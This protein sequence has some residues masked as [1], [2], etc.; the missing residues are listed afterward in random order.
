MKATTDIAAVRREK[1]RLWSG[2]ESARMLAADRAY[3]IVAEGDSWFDYK[4]GLD[5][6][7]FLAGV[8]G[9]AIARVVDGGD[10]LENMAYG[11]ALTRGLRRSRRQQITDTIAKVRRYQ[12]RIVLLSAG[13]N[14][15]S[16]SKVDRNLDNL[17]NHKESRPTEALRADYLRFLIDTHLFEAFGCFIDRVA[18]AMDPGN[19]V[20][21][22][23]HGYGHVVPDG[24]CVG[25]EFGKRLTR[26]VGPWLR[27]AFERKGYDLSE[28]TPI[29]VQ[30]IDRFNEMLDRLRAARPPGQFV[31]V[32]LRPVIGSRWAN[33]LH[34][35]VTAFAD[36]ASLFASRI[37]LLPP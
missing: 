1:R 10:T 21:V 35:R 22:V 2:R 7:D 5:I 30:I 26:H 36:I 34:P 33:E 24:R 17:L 25:P 13:G 37:A 8:H 3:R 28:S 31:Y 6:L 11:T 9:Y 12:P 15:L 19:A 32:D 20:T 27:P 16:G 4:I 23:A 18:N 14:D 29:M